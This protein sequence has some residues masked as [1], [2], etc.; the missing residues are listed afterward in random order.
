MFDL[1]PNLHTQRIIEMSANQKKFYEKLKQRCKSNNLDKQV[2]YSNK[3][4]EI[5]K[6]HQV[7]CGF[8]KA[9]D[10]EIIELENKKMKELRVYIGGDE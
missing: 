1:P 4:T 7:V 6:L 9:D 10:G 8:S 3:L 5:I 2:S